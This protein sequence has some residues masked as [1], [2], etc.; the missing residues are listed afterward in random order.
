LRDFPNNAAALIV[1]GNTHAAEGD[2]T[3]A[4]ESWQRSL[5]LDPSRA[6]AYQA[7]GEVALK[8][9][10][11]DQALTLWRKAQQIAPKMPGVH[12]CLARA[13]MNLR[14]PKEAIVELEKEIEISR[15]SSMCHYLLG[16][17]YFQVEQFDQ[18]RQNYEKA[19]QLQ[20]DLWNAH[21]GLA[22]VYARLG[23][24]A[25][26]K[27]SRETFR[28]L[29][30]QDL[31]V[32]M[33]RSAGHDDLREARQDAARTYTEA[34]VLYGRHADTQTAE[35]YWLRAAALDPKNTGCRESLGALY[36]ANH[37]DAAALGVYEQLREI[38]PRNPFY[39][40]SLGVVNARL[41]RFEAA[42]KALRRA[43]EL[44]PQQS[45]GYRALAQ[46]YLRSSRNLREARELAQKAVQLEPLAPNY[47][48][49]SEAQD[50]NG[51]RQGAVA[52]L[53]RAMQLDPDNP[54]YRRI[55]E[56][57]QRR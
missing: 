32:S 23:Q 46:L 48:V 21:Y 34:A 38:D 49:L 42:E 50:K 47:F 44:A 26:A 45:L 20:P 29:K 52:A 6:D 25:L 7:M 51:D 18:A 22:L 28:K 39:C 2:S 53:R 57:L 41:D 33:A 14:R 9:G 54:T 40:V 35:Q 1:V 43:Q 19:V 5:E 15:G 56:L 10:Q 4:L 55:Y 16:Q 24:A 3:A 17:A 37:R 13:L 27:Q 31:R 36:E 11:F 30:S 8:K 12:Y